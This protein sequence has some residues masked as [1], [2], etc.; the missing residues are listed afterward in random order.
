MRWRLFAGAVRDEFDVE[1][2]A[3]N[4]K[5]QDFARHSAS[6]RAMSLSA[7]RLPTVAPYR[8][9]GKAPTSGR[10]LVC[11]YR[12]NASRAQFGGRYFAPPHKLSKTCNKIRSRPTLS[13]SG[14]TVTSD[15]MSLNKP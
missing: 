4:G 6:V 10:G 14:N 9:H 12:V 1:I 8:R 11:F 3:R 5:D 7:N 2:L 13:S 15:N